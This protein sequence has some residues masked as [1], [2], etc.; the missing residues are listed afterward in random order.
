MNRI[1]LTTLTLCA[2]AGCSE[3]AGVDQVFLA[4]L[5]A[6]LGQ[7]SGPNQYATPPASDPIMPHAVRVKVVE[8]GD[9]QAL[10][11]NVCAYAAGQKYPLKHVTVYK[12]TELNLPAPTST[13]VAQKDCAP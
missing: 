9:A 6:T 2:L 13:L 1:P 4:G 8:N 12:H 5:D 7:A 11:R 10:I 3:P